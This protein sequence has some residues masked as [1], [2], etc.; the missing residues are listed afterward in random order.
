MT[1][2]EALEAGIVIPIVGELDTFKERDMMIPV[3]IGLPMVDLDVYI[4][5][6]INIYWG[7]LG[8]DYKWRAEGCVPL[9]GVKAWMPFPGLSSIAYQVME[10]KA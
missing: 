10:L 8:F 4:T 9:D 3:N 7:W 1:Y 2:K 5:D 6:G